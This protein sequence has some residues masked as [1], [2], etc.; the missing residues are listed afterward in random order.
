MSYAISNILYASGLEPHG[1][2]VFRHAVGIARQFGAKLHVITVTQLGEQP[3]LSD[4]LSRDELDRLHRGNAERSR[5]ILEQRIEAFCGAHPDLDPRAVIASV[6]VL[7]GN[8]TKAVLATAE[9]VGADLIVLGSH[10]H[11]VLGELLVG[12]VA[13]KVTVESRV[14]VLLVP[15][16]HQD[17]TGG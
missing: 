14:P 13:H 8:V 2:E 17:L 7:D 9:Q 3:F 16:N 4:F 10:G 12:S 1:P 11:S 15:I 5:A 6:Q